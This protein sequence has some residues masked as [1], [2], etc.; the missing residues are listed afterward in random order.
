M[1]T[2]KETMCC[3][4]MQVQIH[5]PQASKYHPS[6]VAYATAMDNLYGQR[7]LLMMGTIY[8]AENSVGYPYLK[9]LR[10][11]LINA[12]IFARNMLALAAIQELQVT[13]VISVIQKSIGHGMMF[14]RI[15]VFNLKAKRYLASSLRIRSGPDSNLRVTSALIQRS[16]ISMIAALKSAVYAMILMI[17]SGKL[18]C[19]ILE[20]N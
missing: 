9:T 14:N 15:K 19:F 16:S 7:Q 20:W 17:F 18:P 5:L 12:L 8:L 10:K 4:Q 6:S 1:I 2:A 3:H 13:D 11:G